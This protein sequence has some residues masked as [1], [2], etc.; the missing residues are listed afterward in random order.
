[1]RYRT[2]LND[3]VDYICWKFYGSTD[4]TAEKVYLA[5][6]GLADHGPELPR[7]LLVEL[8]EI[9]PPKTTDGVKLWD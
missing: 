7:G 9:E 2:L 3:T 4:G 1:M 5:N 8:P 6:P